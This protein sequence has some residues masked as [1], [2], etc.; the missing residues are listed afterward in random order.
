MLKVKI[1]ERDQLPRLIINGE[2]QA[3]LFLFV[4]T[5]MANK[6]D[7]C[8]QEI[9]YARKAGM[10]LY[11]ACIHLPIVNAIKESYRSISNVLDMMI[12]EDPEAKIL[13]RVNI[14]IYGRNAVLWGKE[15]PGDIMQFLV[16]SAEES[17]SAGQE[18]DLFEY[19]AAVTIA[20]DD[21]AAAAKN[22]FAYMH[23]L[24]AENP[25]YDEHLLGYHIGAAET[26]EW[27]HCSLRERGI[28]VSQTNQKAF[29]KFL[30]KKYGDIQQL[31][32]A[33]SE[34]GR[35]DS[36]Q[37]ISLPTDIPANDRRA[38]SEI[39]LFTALEHQRFIDYSD[40]ASQIVADRIEEFAQFVRGLIGNEKLIVFFYGY[41]FDL[42]DP[43][44]GHFR[45]EQ[46]LKCKEINALS[47][48]ICYNDRNE[49]GVGA[50]M[51]P[52]DSVI[53]SGK[54]WLVEN[55]IRNCV[56]IKDDEFYDWVKPIASVEKYNEITK[57]ELGQLLIH[58]VGCWYMDLYARGWHCQQNIWDQFQKTKEIYE[59][60]MRNAEEFIPDL[61]VV[62]DES[63]MSY[64]G[65]AEGCGRQLLYQTRLHLYRAGIKF[66]L[67]TMADLLANRIKGY[68]AVLLL[69][70]F[71]L[72]KEKAETIDRILTEQKAG[73]ISLYGFGDSD[74]KAVA[75]LMG[76]EFETLRGQKQSLNITCTAEELQNCELIDQIGAN[77]ITCCSQMQE[78]L[79]VY[80]EGVCEGKAAIGLSD[81][82]G[83]MRIFVGCLELSADLIRAL[84]RICGIHIYCEQGQCL[85][86]GNRYITLYTN[87]T[88][89][90]A[91]IRLPEQHKLQDLYTGELLNTDRIKKEFR[92]FSAYS[93]R[94]LK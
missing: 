51:S 86:V 38:D 92:P 72:T 16:D 17:Q 23:K 30:V 29:Q 77:P 14:S 40:Y 59:E 42:Y 70:P 6:M 21:W 63:A 62:V 50:F 58:N 87:E 3:P 88:A 55:D 81:R 57:R 90:A 80:R 7:V 47:S 8:R 4:N 83:G 76:M 65:T 53:K 25:V 60:Q 93:Y 66:G 35:Y 13:L 46:V 43:R 78:V 69:T 12:E 73:L 56:V 41:Y 64:C 82:G 31:C 85:H 45:L 18:D 32:Q 24:L 39:T 68:Q 79:A 74:M 11:S 71:A 22:S 54:L 49:G 67:Y 36:F 27:F 15:H 19:H 10:H 48:P 84:C 20:S 2:Q 44:T 1:E 33:W 91:E 28:D 75:Q 37:E 89:T 5:E 94:I 61:A 52:V 26:G 34:P 9:R